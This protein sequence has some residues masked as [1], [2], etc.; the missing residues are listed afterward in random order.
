[1][2]FNTIDFLVSIRKDK[3][4]KDEIHNI[5]QDG[6]DMSGRQNVLQYKTIILRC[7]FNEKN[8]GFLN[9]YQNIID[10]VLP[11]PDDIDNDNKYK[12]VPFQPTS[13][14]DPNACICNV[15][16]NEGSNGT[17]IM[18]TEEGEYFEE[19]MIVEFKYNSKLEEGWKWVPLRVRYDKTA[20]L[21]AGRPNY[22]NAY[23]VANNNW[24]SIHNPISEE[25][26]TTG[27]GLPE[28]IEDE[29]IYYNRST[30]ES[31][32]IALR[33]FHNLYVKN[34]LITG[35]SQRKD[36]LIDF[37][38][39]KAG[40]LSK[41]IQAKLGFVF[42]IDISKDN[43]HNNLDGACARYL[44]ARKEYTVI[45]NVM[46][47]NGNSGSNIRS[48]EAI[49]T[50]KDKMIARAIFG[51]GPKDRKILGE[52]VYKNYGI[53][54]EG[55]NVSSCQFAMHYFFENPSTLHG[56]LRNVAECTCMG[57]YFIGTCYD[58]KT[59]FNLLKNKLQN[60]S[61]TIM[62]GNKKI[63]EITKMYNETGFPDDEASIGYP[64]NVYQETINK[65][66]REYLVNFDY[67]VQL[68]EDYGFVLIQKEECA[69][70]DIPNPSGLF[71]ELFTKMENEIG[72]NTLKRTKY[73]EAINM[74]DE[75]RRISFM[76]R[77][78]IFKKMRTV[79]TDKIYKILSKYEKNI[80]H[81]ETQYDEHHDAISLSK[82][83]LIEENKKEN[84]I[85][86]EKK[87]LLI[88]KLRKPKMTLDKYSP[89]IDT[90]DL[91]EQKPIEQTIKIAPILKEQV[92]TFKKKIKNVK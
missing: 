85:E 50:E 62:R 4:G 31:S 72:R 53:A 76:N 14:Y 47:I 59:V 21:R 71:S 56:F 57:G 8:H 26:I 2:E 15:L 52:G 23:H 54:S 67:F 55:F 65:V 80:E 29:G 83:L 18:K 81:I 73:G 35:V 32:T 19:D 36:T 38:V 74:S 28:F 60:E 69:R 58:G 48:G 87:P 92:V 30:E 75:E 6:T 24:H 13:P 33:N 37:A 49:T 43:I 22:G 88:R 44:K 64:I 34:K 63:Y 45:P 39:G 61:I 79:N 20:E 12:P 9:P 17:M 25:M 5:F 42:G 82:E 46:F 3:N 27:N 41:W 7:G 11:S 1:V 77:Y 84:K 51:N 68:M 16:L 10:D 78:F 70:F 89:I 66:F 40:D 86:N 90:P 91:V